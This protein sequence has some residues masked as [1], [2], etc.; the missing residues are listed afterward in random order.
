M[1]PTRQKSIE[2]NKAN[3]CF[4]VMGL[5]H[6]AQL[7][8]NKEV[9]CENEDLHWQAQKKHKREEERAPGGA[10]RHTP[11]NAPPDP[12]PPMRDEVGAREAEKEKIKM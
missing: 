9:E 4:D 2:F 12:P 3:D 1:G 7:R 11:S 10:N 8:R 5:S 6:M